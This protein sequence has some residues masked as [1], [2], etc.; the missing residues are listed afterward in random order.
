M[1]I[2][3]VTHSTCDLPESLVKK[4]K[5]TVVPMV[6]VMGGREYHDGVD[7]S[8]AEFYRR[9]PET[10]PTVT[11]AAPG[12]QSYKDAYEKLA[13][14]GASEILSI[15]ISEKFSAVVNVARQAALEMKNVKVTVLDSQQL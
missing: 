13:K 5:I 14:Q 7:I 11:T 2:G 1:K 10:K 9:L 8:H 12:I 6:I 15:H 3:I 4:E